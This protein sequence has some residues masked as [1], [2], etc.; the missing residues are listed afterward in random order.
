MVEQ[1]VITAIDAVG[2]LG[3]ALVMLAENLFPPIPSEVVLP[4][5]GL[6]VAQGELGYV[7]A[8]LAATAGST[9]GA[10][11]L[12]AVGALGGLPLVLRHRR[13]LRLDVAQIERAQRWSERWGPL[14]VL[15][16][17]TVPLARSLVS[18]PAGM[19]RMPLAL[20]V[21]LTAL[22]SL[23]WNALLIGAG[24]WLGSRWEEASAAVGAGSKVVL[25][26]LALAV[27]LLLARVAA[28]R[29]RERTA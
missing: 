4:L 19:A 17:R 3:L 14:V 28:R 18:V 25:G 9:A 21:A 22:G 10:L 13:L 20:F 15:V 6:A 11:L 12:Y 26:L 8:V 2:L 5:A 23:A 16:A 29:R 1:W 7:P 27:A 24:W